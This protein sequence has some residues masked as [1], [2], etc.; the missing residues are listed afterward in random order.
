V[1][2]IIGS[3]DDAVVR[4]VTVLII[5]CPHALG[6]AIPLVIAISTERAAKSGALIKD[7]LALEHMRTI[8]VVLFDKTGTLAVGAHAVTDIRAAVGITERDL[9]SLA[10]A[11]EADSGHP[12]ARAIVAAAAAHPEASRRPLRATGFTA[13]SGRGIRA[14]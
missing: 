14:T 4:A 11:A 8:D 13:S 6:L 5:A 9:L 2:T 1:W 10:A 7:R 3:P 12:V